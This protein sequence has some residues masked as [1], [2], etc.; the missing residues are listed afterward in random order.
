MA[1]R[2]ILFNFIFTTQLTCSSLYSKQSLASKY[3]PSDDCKSS[4]Y[5][6]HSSQYSDGSRTEG[7]S[8]YPSN[9]CAFI[10]DTVSVGSRDDLYETRSEDGKSKFSGNINHDYTYYPAEGKTI[11]RETKHQNE[12]AYGGTNGGIPS[13]STMT[14]Q[15]SSNNPNLSIILPLVLR[16][17]RLLRTKVPSYP[18]IPQ[19]EQ[20]DTKPSTSTSTGTSASSISIIDLFSHQMH[21]DLALE[22]F[23]IN[24]IETQLPGWAKQVYSVHYATHLITATLEQQ[25]GTLDRV[26]EM[27][28][29]NGKL[30]D[31]VHVTKTQLIKPSGL[32][33][34]HE[35]CLLPETSLNLMTVDD[36]LSGV[37]SKLEQLGG[38][39]SQVT[40]AADLASALVKKDQ[41]IMNQ[42][43]IAIEQAYDAARAKMIKELDEWINNR[44][45]VIGELVELFAKH[46][47]SL[48]QLRAELASLSPTIAMPQPLSFVEVTCNENGQNLSY[49][50]SPA[51]LTQN[52]E[53]IKAAYTFARSQQSVMDVCKGHLKKALEKMQKD[54]DVIKVD[55]MKLGAGEGLASSIK[56]F[57]ETSSPDHKYQQSLVFLLDK[58]IKDRQTLAEHKTKAETMIKPMLKEAMTLATKLYDAKGETGASTARVPSFVTI[59]ESLEDLK[60]YLVQLKTQLDL[61][62][63]LEGIT[64]QLT[65]AEAKRF[66]FIPQKSHFKDHSKIL[67][68]LIEE[69]KNCVKG[70]HQ[71]NKEPGAKDKPAKTLGLVQ[72]EKKSNQKK[73]TDLK[74]KL[75]AEKKQEKD[76]RA[77]NDAKVNTPIASFSTSPVLFNQTYRIVSTGEKKTSSDKEGHLSNTSPDEEKY[78]DENE[79]EEQQEEEEDE[80]ET[81]GKG[82]D[83]TLS[84]SSNSSNDSLII[85]NSG[86]P[87]DQTSQLNIPLDT[88]TDSTSINSIPSVPQK[89]RKIKPLMI[90]ILIAIVLACLGLGGILFYKKFLTWY[91]KRRAKKE[92][93]EDLKAHRDFVNETQVD[94]SNNELPLSECSP[95]ERPPQS[96][97]T[98]DLGKLISRGGGGAYY[99][100]AAV[101]DS[102]S[103]VFGGGVNDGMSV[104]TMQNDGK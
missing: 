25:I 7:G 3:T 9:N 22:Q 80:D 35:Q 68:R 21:I 23:I 93:L 69:A 58:L 94:N 103:T 42:A 104:T 56:E 15:L 72:L 66:R 51:F 14:S 44:A 47:N 39:T 16:K 77:R 10:D 75:S 89:K 5:S 30:L 99:N 63:E 87:I 27:V 78:S 83:N 46:R 95:S 45:S 4:V 57:K 79:K 96:T 36:R 73:L 84:E 65:L 100:Y 38:A 81:D 85:D 20:L 2:L 49:R 8:G 64:S 24:Y 86:E 52:L 97:M 34:E 76:K 29:L 33:N 62:K 28:T 59:C 67:K 82:K 101:I 98:D 71:V 90:I 70:R 31:L 50:L 61:V 40:L 92:A 19:L 74:P 11:H 55:L 37:V 88:S 26:Q 48:D 54:S 1:M 91:K 32:D 53:G 102:A 17:Y 6:N 60:H 13:T 41:I 43:M 18:P 12:G